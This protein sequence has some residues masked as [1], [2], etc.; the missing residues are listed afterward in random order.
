MLAVALQFSRETSKSGVTAMLWALS[1]AFF[2]EAA[3]TG[4]A[5]AWIGAGLAG[6]FSLYFYPTG[7]LW[8]VLAAAYCLYL[9]AHGLGGRRVAI[10][11]GIALAASQPC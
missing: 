2:L 1:V 11:R 6:G 4:R 8:A 7:R 9:L 3:R 10:L 5:W